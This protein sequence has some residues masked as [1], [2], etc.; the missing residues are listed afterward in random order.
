MALVDEQYDIDGDPVLFRCTEC[1][2]TEQSLGALHAHIERHRG[3]TRWGIQVPLTRTAIANRDEL[4]A[5]TE[6]LRVRE[7][8]DVEL[9]DVPAF[10][11]RASLLQRVRAWVGGE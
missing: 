9:S 3:Y 4:M 6:V 2:Y 10:G 5:R 1:G 8:E 11:E 7:T